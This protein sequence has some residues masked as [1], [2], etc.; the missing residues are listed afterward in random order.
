MMADPAELEPGLYVVAT[1]IGHL[2]D[3]SARALSTLR[4]ADLVAAEDTRV[5]Q[6][7]LGHYG[8]EQRLVSLHEHNEEAV[9]ERLVTALQNGDAVALVSDAGTPLISDPGFRLVRA[10]AQAGIAVFTV[11]GPSAVTAALSISGLPTD[12]FTFEGFMPSRRAAR[13]AALNA[14]RDEPR[15]LVFFES[16]HRIAASLADLAEVFGDDRE[17]CVCRELTKRFETVLR[18]SLGA[19]AERVERDPDQRRGEFVVVVAGRSADAAGDLSEAVRLAERLSAHLP[20]SQA[21]RIAAAHH[22]V[23]RRAVYD[24]MSE[25]G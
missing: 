14:L 20:R 7:L 12:R 5:T 2:S 15:T 8:I 24:R 21:A 17:G 1:P 11:P 3:V 10:A 13:V 19:L 16:S 6:R 4:D 25:K 18:G 22:D 9:T 23:S